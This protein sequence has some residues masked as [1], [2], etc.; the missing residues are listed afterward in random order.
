M[1]MGQKIAD[2]PGETKGFKASSAMLW[3]LKTYAFKTLEFIF[4]LNY[5][6][7]LLGNAASKA[8][9]NEMGL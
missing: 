3:E 5:Q 6:F 7:H 8:N 2:R 9:I 1:S 4:F